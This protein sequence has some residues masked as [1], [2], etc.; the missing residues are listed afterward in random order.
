MNAFE[1]NTV[2]APPCW[3]TQPDPEPTEPH[4]PYDDLQVFNFDNGFV[5]EEHPCGVAY[6]VRQGLRTL[7]KFYKAEDALR[8][9]ADKM[10]EHDEE[11]GD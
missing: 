7:A 4:D 10:K 6:G 8:Y 1:S 9:L 3:D 11:G 5:I 2:S